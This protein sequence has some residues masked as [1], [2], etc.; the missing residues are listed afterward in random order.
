MGCSKIASP[1][2][3]W[4]AALL[5]TTLTQLLGA[6]AC[7]QVSHLHDLATDPAQLSGQALP[8]TAVFILGDGPQGAAGT[9][10]P[11]FVV[12]DATGHFQIDGLTPG[13]NRLLFNDLTGSG[14]LLDTVV[15]GG[16]ATDLGMV[17]LTPLE[18]LPG[19]LDLHDIG[20]EERVSRDRGDHAEPRYVADGSKV[21]TQRTLP[22][23][24]TVDIVETDTATGTARV[25]VPGETPGGYLGYDRVVPELFEDRF[26]VYGAKRP[27]P[28]YGGN[29]DAF[30]G[31]DVTADPPAPV[32]VP[33]TSG[34]GYVRG[35]TEQSNFLY[36]A[37][38]HIGG[39]ELAYFVF[40]GGTEPNLGA[41][42]APNMPVIETCVLSLVDASRRCVRLPAAPA[43]YS[44]VGKRLTMLMQGAVQQVDLSAAQLALKFIQQPVG[45]VY[46][47]HT[48]AGGMAMA[49]YHP[50]PSVGGVLLTGDLDGNN[51]T[52]VAQ[53]PPTMAIRT[54]V[55]DDTLDHALVGVGMP[56]NDQI[57]GLSTQGQGAALSH[58]VGLHPP[59]DQAAPLQP[60][61]TQVT[62]Q[63]QTVMLR[64]ICH[65]DL[66]SDRAVSAEQA[67]LPDSCFAAGT[68]G[69]FLAEAVPDGDV[70]MTLIGS[71][72]TNQD[73]LVLV[74][75][76]SQPSG[77]TA[78]VVPPL[79]AV[80]S[81]TGQL[82]QLWR[83]PQ[84]GYVQV[85]LG[86]PAG[87]GATGTGTGTGDF[88]TSTFVSADHGDLAWT[89]S[90][91]TLLYFTRDPDRGYVGLFRIDVSQ[92]EAL[93]R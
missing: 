24:T 79:R 55:A 93:A 77:A 81:P 33:I 71:A 43:S 91:N 59:A 88:R 90:G 31:L 25:L 16:M 3:L 36:S 46:A 68:S 89:D 35:P 11:P 92:L 58:L 86:P 85:Q 38:V 45:S 53:V 21:Y 9:G 29:T 50:D 39:G 84:S 87:G 15:I 17:M 72:C 56:D 40:V 30:V 32:Q 2:S 80:A 47:V 63:G 42:D 54:V 51:L 52:P 44:F 49:I 75:D 14:A 62:V 10:A 23:E 82:A 64:E 41:P 57:P 5:V 73:P 34:T 60:L 37:P 83:D 76:I 69:T 1:S 28:V 67:G 6:S 12:A 19:V 70:C 8:G 27:D 20:Y 65:Y 22:G 26:Y 13:H 66:P 18:S 7:Q 74:V 4:R 61:P 78:T 48:T